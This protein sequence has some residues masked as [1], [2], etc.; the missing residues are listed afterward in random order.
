MI[1]FFISWTE[2]DP[3]FQKYDSECNVLLSPSLLTSEWSIRKWDVKPKAIFIDSGSYSS[4]KYLPVS[5]IIKDQSRI[6]SG[7]EFNNNIYFAHP[8]VMLPS[9][10]TY[11]EEIMIIRNNLERAKEY[12]ELFSKNK[13]S[14][15]PVGIIQA[16]CEEDL[17]CSYYHLKEIGYEYY[18]IGSISK[19]MKVEKEI[20]KNTLEIINTHKLGPIHMF[21]I[22]LPLIA[23][24]DILENVTSFDT[25]TP[26]KLGYYGT[27]LYTNPFRRYLIKPN[28]H[29]KHRDNNF[30][31]RQHLEEPIEC[32]CPI[33][34]DN[35]AALIQTDSKTAKINRIIHNYFQIKFAVE[36]I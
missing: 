28:S 3:L 19:R 26:I 17:L 1:K 6:S 15:I 24:S 12:I 36:K 35:R 33:C 11:D 22:T 29:Q 34:S 25:S 18:A 30:A 7:W 4:N 14:G 16:S 32:H 9:G 2:C 10:S 21:G 8:D 23:D 27:V 5:E 13:L 20:L 31:F